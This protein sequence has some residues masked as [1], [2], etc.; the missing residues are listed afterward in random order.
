MTWLTIIFRR[1]VKAKAV[2]YAFAAGKNAL[3]R[4]SNTEAIEHFTHVLQNVGEDPA[5]DEERASA[6]EGLGDAFFA[7]SLFNEATKTF[8]HL[9]DIGTGVVR[10]RAYRKAM[11]AAFYQGD[12]TH[13]VELVE[14]AE[15]YAALDRLE[16][17]RV[18][19]NKGRIFMD[20]HKMARA[21]EDFEEA[22]RVFEEEYSLWDTAWALVPVGLTSAIMGKPGEGLVALLRSIAIFNEI[23][24]CSRLMDA[25]SMA[26]TVFG[27]CGLREERLEMLAKTVEIDEKM[28]MGDYNKLAHVNGSWS[29]QREVAGD[30]AG[31]LSK[32]LKALEH[33]G[34]TDSERW[35]GAIFADLVRQYAKLGDLTHAEEYFEKLIKLPPQILSHRPAHFALTKAVFLA[36]KKQWKESARYFNEELEWLKT[37]PPA[38][39]EALIRVNLAW[40]L[41]QQGRAEEARMQSEVVQQLFEKAEKK[42][43]HVNLH[44]NLMAL[45]KMGVGQT[46]D[47]RLDLINVSTNSGTIVKV[48][49]LIPPEFKILQNGI[50]GM[51]ERKISPFQVETFKLRLKASKPGNYTFNPLVFYLDE[52]GETKTCKP[53]PINYYSS[54]GTAKIRSVAQQG[55]PQAL[56][57]LDAL[58]FGGIPQNY[59]VALTS[60]SSDERAMLSKT[61][62]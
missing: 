52:R 53:T 59:A 46:F 38:T 41:G 55:S 18:R 12:S 4:F 5:H 15:E 16:S 6:L 60:P 34:K 57:R 39:E 47:A 51:K 48:E 42:F 8:E 19:V 14:K 9:A 1:G 61:V 26:S 11:D 58:L 30:L 43:E 7:N 24:D 54:A 17:A 22:L 21:L 25:Y 13:L 44:A 37:H 27:F 35:L 31:A 29:R 28:K 3:T 45:T 36:T 23:G 40:A 2:K 20:Q 49:E 62:P 56:Q 32:S 33:S 50:T 10:L